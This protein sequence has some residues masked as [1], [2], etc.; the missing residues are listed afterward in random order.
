[1]AGENTA[2]T[3]AALFQEVYAKGVMNFLPD[4]AMLVKEV[5]FGGAEAT[6][7]GKYVQPVILTREHGFTY[8]GANSGAFALAGGDP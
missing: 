7:G 8:A 6:P 1:M 5:K 3:L 2:V 4:A